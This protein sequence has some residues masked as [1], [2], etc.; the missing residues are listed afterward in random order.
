[1]IAYAWTCHPDALTYLLT[2]ILMFTRRPWAVA[3]VAALGAWT[4]LAMWGVVCV[5]AVILWFAFAE[6]RARAVAA[7]VGLVV[8]AGSCALALHLCGIE[9]VRQ[10]YRARF[11]PLVHG[12]R[13]YAAACCK[14]RRWC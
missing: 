4:H 14:A 11:G 8:G 6:P 2:V 7:G 5:N 9:I 10:E 1:M 12:T 3:V 13:G